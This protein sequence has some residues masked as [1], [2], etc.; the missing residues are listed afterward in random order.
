MS[1][2]RDATNPRCFKGTS[3]ESNIEPWSPKERLQ[4]TAVLIQ[5]G[6]YFSQQ[7]II[8]GTLT[9]GVNINLLGSILGLG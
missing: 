9:K 4:T 3:R 2:H 5:L 1:R 8:P 7:G 6:I